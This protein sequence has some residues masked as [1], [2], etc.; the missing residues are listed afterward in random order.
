M[1]RYKSSLHWS[2]EL[3]GHRGTILPATTLRLVLS[4]FGDPAMTTPPRFRAPAQLHPL[5]FTV[6][7][8]GLA[9]RGDQGSRDLSTILL[10]R[11][12]DRLLQETWPAPHTCGE[13]VGGA[14]SSPRPCPPLSDPRVP[15]ISEI[16]RAHLHT[17]AELAR[18]E[19]AP[20]RARVQR[21]CRDSSCSAERLLHRARGVAAPL[22]GSEDSLR[23]APS[24]APASL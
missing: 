11:A 12:R 18:P 7:I 8:L 19:R 22:A 5:A 16:L 13:R 17:A 2:R 14:A 3:L 21:C 1:D 24:A 20:W 15:P 6:A 9:D 23:C 4:S 10:R